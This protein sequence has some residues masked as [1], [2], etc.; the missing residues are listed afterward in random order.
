MKK[1][2]SALLAFAM[3]LVLVTGCGK[4]KEKTTINIATISGPTG[5]GMVQLMSENKN[6]TSENNYNFDVVSAPDAIVSKI[7]GGECDI[8]AVPTNLASTLYQKTTGGVQILAVNTLGVLSVLENGNSINSVA[9]LKGKEIYTTGQGSNPEYILNYVLKQNGLEAGTDVKINFLTENEELAQKVIKGEAKVA[10][11]PQPVATT[12]MTKNSSVRIALD[13]TE[14]WSKVSE[15]STLMM[16]CVIARKEFTDKNKDAVK[17]FL[18]EYKASIEKVNSDVKSAAALCEEFGIIP[19][20]AL[21]EKAIPKCNITY[22]D[23][24]EM[25]NKLTGYLTVLYNA[26]PASVGGKLPDDGFFFK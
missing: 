14:E 20:A 4:A 2:T 24:S 11:V 21:A 12:I 3:V 9:D 13:M 7:S 8:A 26:K 15:D 23:G 18:K 16:G 25:Q 22:V 19:S 17:D 1:I 6:Q 5:I 10:L